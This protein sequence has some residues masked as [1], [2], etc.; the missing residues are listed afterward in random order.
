MSFMATV[1][2][3]RNHD[4]P[5]VGLNVLVPMPSGKVGILNITLTPQQA[6]AARAFQAILTQR[7]AAALS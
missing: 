2:F 1:E 3:S 4:T 6:E 5:A 7:M